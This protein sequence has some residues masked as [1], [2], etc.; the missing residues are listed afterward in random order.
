L[1][2]KSI[3]ALGVAITVFAHSDKASA[4]QPSEISVKVRTYG[5]DRPRGPNGWPGFDWEKKKAVLFGLFAPTGDEQALIAEAVSQVKPHE[6]AASRKLL[7]FYRCQYPH[8]SIATGNEA[9]KKLDAATG[10]YAATF[11]DDPADITTDNLSQ[12][13]AL[14]LNN[15]TDFDITVGPA[16]QKAILDYVKSGHGLIGIHAAADSCKKW[17]SGQ[18]LI[19]GIFRCHPWLPKGTWAFQLESPHHRLNAAFG[20]N[21]FWHRDEVYVYRPGSHSRAPSRV[22]VSLDPTKSHN[23]EAKELHQKLKLMASEDIPRPVAWI[24]NFGDGR[25]FYSNLGH[26]NTTFWQPTVLQHYLDGIQY[27]LGDIEA[28]ATPSS[29]LAEIEYARAPERD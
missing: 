10:A 22:L 20:G 19:N 12:Y 1:R 15:T 26:N 28:D 13:D 18:P 8:A 21:G 14:L 11:T 25:V 16:G 2:C 9:F 7:V 4:A 27:A 24:H 17:K 29:D 5:S 3:L 6:P 23:R